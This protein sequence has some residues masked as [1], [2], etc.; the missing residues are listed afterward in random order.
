MTSGGMSLD[1]LKGHAGAEEEKAGSH[2]DV[3][4]ETVM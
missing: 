1:K 2:L 4:C 3:A